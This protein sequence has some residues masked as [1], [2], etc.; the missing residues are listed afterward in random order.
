MSNGRLFGFALLFLNWFCPA[1]LHEEI[2]GSFGVFLLVLVT[3]AAGYSALKSGA[4]NPVD[5]INTE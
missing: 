2:E 3:L 1:H 5:A 4:T